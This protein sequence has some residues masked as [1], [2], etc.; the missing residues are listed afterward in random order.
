MARSSGVLVIIPAR[1]GSKRLPG[2]NILSLCGKPLIAWTIEAALKSCIA[3][4]IIVSSDDDEILEVAAQ[5]GATPFKRD[6]NFATDEA[7]TIDVVMECV[8]QEAE[9]G[10]LYDAI[11][12]LQPTSP[13]RNEKDIAGAWELYRSKE[14]NSVITVCEADHPPQWYGYLNDASALE[15][16]DFS[17]SSRSQDFKQSYRINGAVY[18]VSSSY[19]VSERSFY[20]PSVFAYVMPKERSF[21][22]DNKIDFEMCEFFASRLEIEE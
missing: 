16:V 22:I 13:L 9:Q 19:L 12:L 1:G 3:E 20:T 17:S 2:K 18:F 11:L 10:Y 4:K 14:G 6:S 8:E 21:D 15:G 5:Y 7:K